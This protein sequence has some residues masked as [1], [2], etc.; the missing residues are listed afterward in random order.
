MSFSHSFVVPS[1][2]HAQ[3]I[4]ETIESLLAQDLPGS[5]IVV[6]DDHSTDGSRAVIERYR[7]RIRIVDPPVRLGMMPN[8]NFTVSQATGQWISLLGS[9]DRAL[10]GF[11]RAIR[12]AAVQH[13][14]AVLISGDFDHIDGAGK[15]VQHEKVLSMRPVTR[16]P[17]TFRSQMMDARIHP[18]SCAFRR[19]V[20]EKVG[21][22][23]QETRLYGDWGLWL[24][25]S[26]HGSFVHRRQALTEYRVHYR[27]DIAVE[28]RLDALRDDMFIMLTLL[29]EVAATLP[30]IGQREI[31]RAQWKRLRN[32]LGEYGPTVAPADRG[33]IVDLLRPWASH[34]NDL[35]N[36]EK[37]ARGETLATGWRE[38]PVRRFLRDMV[39]KLR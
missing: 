6:C 22:F 34:V 1:Y 27:P 7:D 31:A 28:R 8:Y 13:P 37:F 16:P 12:E 29:P 2:N 19:D 38:S 36:L 26:P 24:R 4:G 11:A 21:G 33:P 32:R 25:M 3:Y 35:P 20:W 23:A 10:P 5:E 17:D 15:L 9:D 30:G 39:R 18:V 14:G